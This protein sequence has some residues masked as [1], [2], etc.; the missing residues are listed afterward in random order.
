MKT[1]F[2]YKSAKRKPAFKANLALVAAAREAEA[3]NEPGNPVLIPNLIIVQVEGGVVSRVL[4]NNLHIKVEIVDMDACDDEEVEQAEERAMA[5][6]IEAN[7]G[8][9]HTLVG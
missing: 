9:L 1:K 7:A 4:S 3:L 6:D 2:I 8:T 5:I